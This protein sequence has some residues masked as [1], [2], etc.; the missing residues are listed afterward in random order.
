MICEL[1]GMDVSMLPYVT[2]PVLLQKQLCWQPTAPGANRY[3]FLKPSIPMP[4]GYCLP[5]ESPKCGTGHRTHE[6]RGND[7]EA[8]KNAVSAKTA[9]ILIKLQTFLDI[10]KR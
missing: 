3:W 1:T 10:W 2:V 7:L 4:E 5:F 9:A 6:R 8:V